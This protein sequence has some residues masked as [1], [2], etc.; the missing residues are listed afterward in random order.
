MKR[1]WSIRARLLAMMLG[2]LIPLLLL[3]GLALK[4]QYDAMIDGRVFMLRNQVQGMVTLA[5][6]LQKEQIDKAGRPVAEVQ[7]QWRETVSGIRYD[8]GTGYF[9]A[10]DDK[11]MYLVMPVAPDRVGQSAAGLK[12]Q[13]GTFFVQKMVDVALKNGEGRVD[14]WYPKPGEKDPLR[15]VSYVMKVPG[16]N[17]V[18][19]TGVYVDDVDAAF[20]GAVR[21]FMIAVA[22]VVVFALGLAWLISRDIVGAV[23][24]L[25]R[26][27]SVLAEGRIPD[28]IPTAR[29]DELGDIGRAMIALRETV[30]RAF[31]LNQ[32]VDEQPARVMLCDRETLNITY[33]NKAS[34]DLLRR[35]EHLMPCKAEEVI[36]KPVSIFHRRHKDQIDALLRD[37]QKLPI[38]SKFSLGDHV[39]ENTVIPIFDQDGGYIG[40]MLNWDDATKYVQMADS[41]QKKVQAVSDA[42]AD[43][44][45]ELEQLSTA[46][47]ATA[48]QVGDRSASVAGAAE[49]AGVN[50]QT[51]ASAAEELSASINEI[52]RSVEHSTRTAQEAVERVG[53]AQE[54]MGSL[55]RSAASIGEVIRLISDIA[56]QTNLLALNAT[57]EAARAGE[58]GKGFAVVANEVKSLATQTARATEDIVRQ[59]EGVQQASRSST[60]ATEQIRDAIDQVNQVSSTVAAA[61]EEQAAATN[62]ISRN[63]AE[64][65]AGT[66]QV[67]TDITAVVQV[68][69]E[70]K[71]AAMRV[72][73]AA[74]DLTHR[75]DSLRKE[76]AD[77]LD[78]MRKS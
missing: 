53:M 33:I 48:E 30:R 65:S 6:T 24:A 7:A 20:Q 13:T 11:V 1:L 16:W 34:M 77:F 66:T 38:R 18:I 69:S 62:E 28:R 37:P 74:A 47:Q 44:A 64:A 75:S 23:T 40:P 52:G 67:S 27:V 4:N 73:S 22:A 10:V 60:Q 59:I 76:V 2:T 45:R 19:G 46:L 5:Q 36:G 35:V 63:V 41:F 58:A 12:D 50:V 42:V 9:F 21:T 31:Q 39:I 26:V 32:M 78:Y 8:N 72:H 68:A 70:A 49:Q 71:E 56:S 14:Y 17:A 55:N 3:V 15:K 25:S 57:I 43:S 29:R 51:V 61:I 54:A